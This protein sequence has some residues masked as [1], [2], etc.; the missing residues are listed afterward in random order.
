LVLDFLP[1][2]AL[3]LY[4]TLGYPINLMELMAQEAGMTVNME[5]FAAEMEG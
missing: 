1:D 3:I 2:K 4:D 5:G